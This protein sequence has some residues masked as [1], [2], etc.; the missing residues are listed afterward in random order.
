MLSMNAGCV[1]SV[2]GHMNTA[3]D[4]CSLLCI[5]L[6]TCR[7]VKNLIVWKIRVNTIMCLDNY[8]ERLRYFRLNSNYKAIHVLTS[9]TTNSTS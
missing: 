3:F 2:N 7:M 1:Q 4:R 5:Q 8:I 9:L 6:I